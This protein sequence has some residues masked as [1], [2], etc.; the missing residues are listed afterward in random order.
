MTICPFPE[1]APPCRFLTWVAPF[2]T[3]DE[4]PPPPK[5]PADGLDDLELRGGLHRVRKQRG[6]PDARIAV[7]DQDSAVPAAR[8]VEEPVERVLLPLATE[9]PATWG[10]H[11]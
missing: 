3:Y 2:S 11:R 8:G 7:H 4:P 10:P 5:E 6:F 1:G 9:Q